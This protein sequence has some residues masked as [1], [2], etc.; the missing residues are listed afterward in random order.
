TQHT[1]LMLLDEPVSNLDMGN[2]IKVLKILSELSEKGIGIIVSSHFPEHSLWLNTM[3]G[4]LR[5][6]TL[7]DYDLA[8]KIITG[9]TLSD[10]YGTPISVINNNGSRYCEPLFVK[11]IQHKKTF[12]DR[13]GIG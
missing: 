6:G 2:Q 7:S 3:T 8:E 1:K 11:E 5:K 12:K 4:I 10:L 9:D 13:R